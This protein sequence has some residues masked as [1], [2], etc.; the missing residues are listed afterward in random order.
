[1]W[2]QQNQI[3]LVNIE[4]KPAFKNSNFFFHFTRSRDIFVWNAIQLRI[5]VNNVG[6]NMG[7]RINVYETGIA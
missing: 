6:L 7:S 3:S 2:W 4:R 5:T 1:M